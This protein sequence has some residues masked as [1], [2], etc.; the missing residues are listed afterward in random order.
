MTTTMDAVKE[1]LDTAGI[2]YSYGDDRVTAYSDWEQVRAAT[3][4]IDGLD[5]ESRPGI[6]VL[7]IA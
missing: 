1:A 5:Y 3:R 2:C 4:T 7:I 6:G